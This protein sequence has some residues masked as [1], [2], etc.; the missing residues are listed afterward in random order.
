MVIDHG[1]AA[2]AQHVVAATAAQEG[3][4]HRDGF[5]MAERLDRRPRRDQAEQRQVHGPRI[6]LRGQDLDGPAL[7]VRA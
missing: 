7:V 1:L 6:R 3:V 5:L 2:H 4:R